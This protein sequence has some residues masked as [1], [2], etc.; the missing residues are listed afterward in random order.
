[1]KAQRPLRLILAGRDDET[2]RENSASVSAFLRIA[3]RL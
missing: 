1:L 2:Y 3:F